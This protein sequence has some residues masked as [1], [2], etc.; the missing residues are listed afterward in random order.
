M[1]F[2]GDYVNS[3]SIKAILQWSFMHYAFFTY[4]NAL[5]ILFI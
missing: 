2:Q 1:Y 5:W 3:F 4:T